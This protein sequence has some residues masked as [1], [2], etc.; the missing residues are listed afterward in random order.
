[1]VKRKILKAARGGKNPY[2][3]QRGKK[4]RIIW[5][6]CQKQGKEEDSGEA[7]PLKYEET[8]ANTEL[9][10]QQKCLSKCRQSKD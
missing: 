8:N 6:S 3:R 2:Y 1:M 5:I 7:T 4:I 9:N 10:T